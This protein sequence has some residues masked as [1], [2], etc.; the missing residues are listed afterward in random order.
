MESRMLPAWAME[1][2][3]LDKTTG[4]TLSY[5]DLCP[6]TPMIFLNHYW[7]GIPD[8]PEWP[9]AKQKYLMPNI[10]MFE[11][12]CPQQ[13]RYCPNACRRSCPGRPQARGLYRSGRPV[14]G[15]A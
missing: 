10:E 3:Y 8:E 9:A 13:H 6:T 12:Q 1:I 15:H 5:H 4:K 11:H 7:D 2:T 14:A